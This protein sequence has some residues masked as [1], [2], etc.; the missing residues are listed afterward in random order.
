MTSALIGSDQPLLAESDLQISGRARELLKDALVWD[1]HAGFSSTPDQD[2][3]QLSRYIDGGVDFLSIN[4]GY[5]A[6]PWDHT[7]RTV[8]AYRH[9]LLQHG[10]QYVVV[11][12]IKDIDRAKAEGKLA[13][14]FDLEGAVALGGQLSMLAVYRKLGVRQ[15]H[16][17]YNLNN[18]AGGGCQDDD[19]GLT[20]FGR[21]LVDEANRLGIVL[22]CSHVGYRSSLE[23]I[24]RSA[25][26]VVFSHSNSKA[27]V[28]HPRNITDEQMHAVASRGGLVGVTGVGRFLGDPE[29]RS[30]T[31]VHAVDIAVQT[32]GIDHVCIGLDYTWKRGAAFSKF[33]AFWPEEHYHGTFAYL[34]PH[35]LPEITE[36]LLRRGYEEKD[37]RALFGGNYYK[38]ARQ[39]WGR[40]D[41]A[42]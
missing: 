23:V 41:I 40:E 33:R 6:F 19:Q 24:D 4:I 20:D 29:A 3:S 18:E 16:F 7:V 26:P 30:S 9:W 39:V 27:V 11:D 25:E 17:V 8:A 21:S 42:V 28:D 34:G 32:V 36:L 13:V 38:L 35:Q 15:M 2:L 22:D 10:D 5:D 12:G 31:F 14:A 1:A 37:I